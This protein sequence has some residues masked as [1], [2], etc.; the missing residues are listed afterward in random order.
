MKFKDSKTF[1]A[2]VRS[3]LHSSYITLWTLL[4]GG[5]NPLNGG[6]G[7]IPWSVGLVVTKDA[8]TFVTNS[9]CVFEVEG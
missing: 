8:G 7:G 3:K 2:Y 9:C 5:I 1:S 6:G 4:E